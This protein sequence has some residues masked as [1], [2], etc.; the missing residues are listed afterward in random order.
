[1]HRR[2]STDL[3][4]PDRPAAA[5]RRPRSRVRAPRAGQP[6]VRPQRP[7]RPGAKR[8]RGRGGEG[9]MVGLNHDGHAWVII[10]TGI[11]MFID[12]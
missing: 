7:A 3:P 12:L 1:M 5:D 2:T 6:T 9:R 4:R 10:G 8:G 11:G